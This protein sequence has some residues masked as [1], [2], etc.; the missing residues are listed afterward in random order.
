MNRKETEKEEHKCE[1]H[2]SHTLKE[3]DVSSGILRNI[4]VVNIEHF[5]FETDTQLK[6]P[7]TH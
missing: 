2:I 7:Y 5:F 3:K 6:V 1:S 4:E